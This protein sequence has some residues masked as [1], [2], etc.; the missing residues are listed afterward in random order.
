MEKKQLPKKTFTIALNKRARIFSY[1]EGFGGI[2]GKMALDTI[3]HLFRGKKC[4]ELGCADG[5]L[6]EEII[7][8]FDKVTAI[9]GSRIQIQRLKKRLRSKKLITT[10]ALAEEIILKDKFDTIVASFLLEHVIDPIEL[11]NHVKRFLKEKGCLL[12][13]VPNGESLHR[14]VAKRM[15]IIDNVTVLSPQDIKDGHL[16][17][18]TFDTLK[19]DV[20]KVGLVIKSW[21][22]IFLKPLPDYF[23]EKHFTLQM[24][25]GFYQIGKELP[26]Y[27]SAIYMELEKK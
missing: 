17:T 10:V 22:G 4:L 20:T 3:K 21:G 8:Y 24:I 11:L 16:R 1:R 14:R 2:I 23:I 18:Y 13:V 7:K 25:E 12:I 26:R 6:T 27:C 19:K 5:L 9:D 15:G